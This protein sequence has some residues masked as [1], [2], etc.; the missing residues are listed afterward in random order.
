MSK[1]K[2]RKNTELDEQ[3]E[4]EDAEEGVTIDAVDT[5]SVDEGTLDI[6]EQ[7]EVFCA[8]CGAFMD[9]DAE[10]C[11]ICSHPV[12]EP[13][14]LAPEEVKKD[15]LTMKIFEWQGEGYDTS[16]L[17][18]LMEEEDP[19]LAEEFERFERNKQRLKEIIQS[20]EDVEGDAR[21]ESEIMQLRELL[22]DPSKLSEIEDEIEELKNKIVINA[23]RDELYEMDTKGLED[24]VS[25]IESLMENP[26]E[27]MDE[28]KRR[29]KDLKRDQQASFFEGV[30]ATE[31]TPEEKKKRRKIK[32]VRKELER[33]G[34]KL[35]IDDLMIIHKDGTLV[36][37]VTRR[38]PE[39]I[40]KMKLK[41]MTHMVQNKVRTSTSEHE[42]IEYA[43]SNI[44]IQIGQRLAMVLVIT[45][46]KRP[47]MDQMLDKSIGLL[48]NRYEAV[49]KNWSGDPATFK[50][51]GK[52]TDILITTFVK[53][54]S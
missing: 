30:I 1:N 49:L 6:D 17:E 38:T 29:I 50:A 20:L 23:L 43:H 31:F 48:E 18:K 16:H 26:T 35:T 11:P 10:E 2:G 51:I 42:E 7:D 3:E 41:Q 37:H 27:N 36:S 34:T 22:N 52:Y 5:D 13:V 32:I 54:E 9:E 25:A 14:E 21:V 53:M 28:I 44:I 39:E 12:G 47:G 33:K 19:N 8:N 46:E 24:K 40:E 45:G 4:P 15:D